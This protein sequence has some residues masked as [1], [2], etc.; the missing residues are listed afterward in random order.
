MI[1]IVKVENNLVEHEKFF[2][3]YFTFKFYELI[4]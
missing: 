1:N 3:I 4:K 2:E